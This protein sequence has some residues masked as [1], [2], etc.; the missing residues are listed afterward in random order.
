MPVEND[1]IWPAKD[2]W[3]RFTPRNLVVGY[4]SLFAALFFLGESVWNL[5]DGGL[6]TARTVFFIAFGIL[7]VLWLV[8]A[9]SGLKVL[10]RRRA[11]R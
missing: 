4:L 8:Q 11:G 1:P 9:T 7:A 5:L 2:P 10:L 6:S 3:Y